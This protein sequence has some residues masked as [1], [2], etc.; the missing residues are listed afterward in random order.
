MRVLQ[1][2]LVGFGLFTVSMIF[3]LVVAHIFATQIGLPGLFS[4]VPSDLMDAE[5]SSVLLGGL[6]VGVFTFLLTG[7]MA[8]TIFRGPQGG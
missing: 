8:L 7:A 2:I 3:G 6:I 4:E 1:T 5:Q